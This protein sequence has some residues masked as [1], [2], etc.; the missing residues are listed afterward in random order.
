MGQKITF[1]LKDTEPIDVDLRIFNKN[2]TEI[3]YFN[4]V[5]NE[6]KNFHKLPEEGFD[7]RDKNNKI[8][9]NGTYFYNLKIKKMNGSII[10][11]TIKTFTFIKK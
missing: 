5:I 11:D 4:E 9:K 8:I 3:A 10:F 7:G 1:N 2:G 6:I